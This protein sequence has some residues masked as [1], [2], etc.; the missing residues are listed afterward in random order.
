MVLY[1][2]VWGRKIFSFSMFYN[3]CNLPNQSNYKNY[4]N[5][6]RQI[7]EGKMVERDRDWGHKYKCNRLNCSLVLLLFF[8][9]D[10]YDHFLEYYCFLNE[11]LQ[12][13]PRYLHR[14][15]EHC[16]SSS[17]MFNKYICIRLRLECVERINT[18]LH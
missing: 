17:R 1:I 7:S 18:S 4:S 8:K 10:I 13:L 3:S 14:V 15:P 9:E 11:L 2:T 12:G 16:C 5:S 6:G